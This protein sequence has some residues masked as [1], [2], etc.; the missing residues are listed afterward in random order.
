MPGAQR[1]AFLIADAMTAC[2]GTFRDMREDVPKDG[3][4]RLAPVS[5]CGLREGRYR[6]CELRGPSCISL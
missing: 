6:R 1:P 4:Q 3:G 2:C 5:S